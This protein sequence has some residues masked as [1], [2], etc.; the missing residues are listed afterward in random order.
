MAKTL[1]KQIDEYFTK[2]VRKLI[3][4]LKISREGVKKVEIEPDQDLVDIAAG[5]GTAWLDADI[6]FNAI[7]HFTRAK[8][9]KW[10]PLLARD[11]R[12]DGEIHRYVDIDGRLYEYHGNWYE[13]KSAK[14][15]VKKLVEGTVK[16]AED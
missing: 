1:D 4:S 6:F 14:A 10:G 12:T 2:P 9:V 15:F 16:P 3:T 8:E 13:R 11:N 5:F 7:R